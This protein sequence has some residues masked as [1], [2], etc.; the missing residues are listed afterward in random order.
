[1]ISL[2]I[3]AKSLVDVKRQMVSQ[4][5]CRE[6]TN[7]SMEQD[8]TLS[9]TITRKQLIHICQMVMA[10]TAELMQIN[11]AFHETIYQ[12]LGKDQAFEV[13]EATSKK[14]SQDK[15]TRY[16]RYL[17]H[18][19]QVKNEF[20][21]MK[22]MYQDRMEIAEKHAINASIDARHQLNQLLHKR[23]EFYGRQSQKIS[24]RPLSALE[25][26]DLLIQWKS[27]ETDASD[28]RY[29]Y[30]RLRQ[31]IRLVEQ[32]LR[33]KN[34]ISKGYLV[35][36]YDQMKLE[37][38]T[39]VEKLEDRHRDL[40]KLRYKIH[41]AIATNSHLKEKIVYFENHLDER[42]S[43]KRELEELYQTKANEMSYHRKQKKII[44]R[45]TD[46]LKQHCGLMVHPR[47]L[48]DYCI[49]K[50]E[51]DESEVKINKLRQRHQT[52]M[53]E[54]QQLEQ[55]I[56]KGKMVVAK[57]SGRTRFSIRPSEFIHGKTPTKKVEAKSSHNVLY[58]KFQVRSISHNPNKVV[59][60]FRR[61]RYY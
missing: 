9:V 36:D 61:S 35:V 48:R 27:K 10:K 37:N 44:R 19:S 45:K 18:L 4:I 30:S 29:E 32:K 23:I 28:I 3:P 17:K 20:F 1:M 39:Y 12:I 25:I 43:K 56:G 14:N 54:N 33:E 46:K 60:G 50:E 24:G 34:V 52:I 5:S 11:E 15:E 41:S 7:L 51:I 6:Q 42:R 2:N 59:A 57:A 31:E 47:L 21:E 53:N 8:C 55:V 49:V 26:R 58:P 38:Q 40:I 16:F 13:P 22:Q